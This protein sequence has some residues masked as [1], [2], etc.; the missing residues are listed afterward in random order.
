MVAALTSVARILAV[1]GR[2]LESARLFGA[3]EVFCEQSGFR[4]WEDF[5]KW[6]RATGLSEPWQGSEEPSD[7]WDWMRAAVVAHGSPVPPLPDPATAAEAWAAGR[8]IS[9][10]EAVTQAFAVDL[11]A[12]SSSSSTS[13]AMK[14]SI[15]VGSGLTAREQEIL[16]LLCERLTDP[17]IA[18]RLFLS[19]RTVESHVASL[20]RKLDVGNRRDAVAAAVQFG[21]V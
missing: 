4:F 6:Q 8:S 12:P 13:V 14:S 9:I 21:L 11:A 18:E 20:L 16:G 5:W 3:A 7:R 10:A 19:P 1:E 17:Q 2:W 15:H